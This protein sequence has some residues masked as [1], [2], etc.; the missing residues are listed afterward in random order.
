MTDKVIDGQ[1]KINEINRNGMKEE[2]LFSNIYSFVSSIISLAILF[3]CIYL[4]SIGEVPGASLL[5]VYMYSDK[6]LNMFSFADRIYKRITEM[7]LTIKNI[8]D[9]LD[10][11]EYA[12]EKFGKLEK[13]HFDGK[14]EFK[15]VTFGYGPEHVLNKI[16]FTI[17][18]NATIGFVGR[19]GSGKSTIFNLISKLYTV[20][21]GGIF[22]DDININDFSEKTLRGNI[23]VISQDPYIF[24][25][26]IKENIRIV[27]PSISDE[28]IIQKC[29]LACL[30]D[31]VNSLP[32]KYDTIVGENGVI[33]SGGLKQRLAIAR[34]LVKDSEIILL[35]EATSSLDNEVQDH[36]MD[37][38]RNISDDYTILIIAHR[39]STVKDCD[40]IIVID[41]GE[42][43]GYDTHEKLMENNLIYR[44]LYRKELL[45]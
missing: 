43:K 22:I 30:D 7:S 37:A 18:S 4:I 41:D 36:I 31:Y 14:I 25:M 40:K 6:V 17:E 12:K 5:I 44:G 13:K 34:A 15:N 21:N 3:Y 2:F 8:F 24:N 45:K 20:E 38:I 42:I 27:K 32:D 28:E 33:L 1:I 16:N 19:S 23:S 26:S 10:S 29:K 11:D 9:I 39:L 35:D